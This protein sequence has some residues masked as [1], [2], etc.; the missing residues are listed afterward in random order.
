MNLTASDPYIYEGEF[1][2]DNGQKIKY[3]QLV[4]DVMA[5]DTKVRLARSL[6]GLE[7]EYIKLCMENS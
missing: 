3:Y 1:E 2:N 4:V 6:K 7:K 5:G